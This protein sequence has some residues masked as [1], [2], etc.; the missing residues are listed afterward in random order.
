LRKPDE[1]RASTLQGIKIVGIDE[2]ENADDSICIN[3][4]FDSNVI[5]ESNLQDAKHCEQRTS[6]SHGITID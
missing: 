4:E 6:T 1:G 5:D 3:R 2:S